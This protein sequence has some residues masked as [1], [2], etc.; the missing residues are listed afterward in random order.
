VGHGEEIG[1]KMGFPTANI[2]LDNPDK[3]LPCDAGYA[4]KVT[5][6]T[7]IHPGMLYIGRRPTFEGLTEQRIEVNIIDFNEEIYGQHIKVELLHFLR[8]EQHFDSME[9]LS[10]QLQNDLLKAKQL[11]NV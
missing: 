5:V 2:L 10:K 7:A 6:G 4:V 3:L 11:L 9:S 8:G 1:H